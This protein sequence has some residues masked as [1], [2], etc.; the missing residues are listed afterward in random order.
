[1]NKEHFSE[2]TKSQLAELSGNQ[3]CDRAGC[4]KQAS[5]KPVIHLRSNALEVP[6]ESFMG[7]KVCDACATDENARDLISGEEA[8]TMFENIFKVQSR[9][10]S[11]DWSCSG[12]AWIPIN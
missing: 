5:F 3:M 12:V 10:K 1:M 7:L 11:V 9:G 2:E 4:N 8:Q 6:C